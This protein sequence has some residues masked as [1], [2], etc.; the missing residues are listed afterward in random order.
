MYSP[1]IEGN[2]VIE[3]EAYQMDIYPTILNA[4][5]CENYYWGGFGVNLLEE[6]VIKERKISAEEALELSDK[7]HQAN[8]FKELFTSN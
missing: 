4:I 5:G 1:D 7:I 2:I 3:E 8:Y 6:D